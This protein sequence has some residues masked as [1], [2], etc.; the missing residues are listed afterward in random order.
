M[1]R[2]D[3]QWIDGGDPPYRSVQILWCIG[4]GLRKSNIVLAGF[5]KLKHGALLDEHV[6]KAKAIGEGHTR[7]SAG[8]YHH[9]EHLRTLIPKKV[10]SHRS[11]GRR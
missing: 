3:F 8:L 10:C 1:P 11:T 4:D 7:S 9:L 6:E 5:F 2:Y